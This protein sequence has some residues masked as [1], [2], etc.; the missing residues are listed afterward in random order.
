MRERKKD[1]QTDRKRERK[2]E[3]KKEKAGQKLDLTV[4]FNSKGR[5]PSCH[6]FLLMPKTSL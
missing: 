3:R 2:R 1:R 4:E 6:G 5:S